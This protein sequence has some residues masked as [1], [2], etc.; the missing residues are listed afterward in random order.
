MTQ[1]TPPENV[2]ECL[3]PSENSDS[4]DS[5]FRLIVEN[6]VDLIVRGDAARNRTYV[7]PSSREI[8]GYEPAEM[9]GKHAYE[10]VHPED[11]QRT[12][13]VFGRIGPQYPCQDLTFRMR[14]SDGAYVWI[15]ARYRHL[16]ADDGVLAVLR[17]ITEQ[18]RAE[19]Q[20]TEANAKLEAANA[21]LRNLAQV[22]GLTGIANRR[23]FDA[24][25]DEEFRRA[26]REERPLGL[27]LVDIDNFKGFNDR[28]GHLGGDD[29]LRRVSRCI[30]EAMRRPG[31]HVARYGGEE[32]AILLPATDALG[33]VEVAEHVRGVV[34]CL[35][36]EHAGS[37]YG[38]VT[39]SAGAA[40]AR[41]HGA[42][43][44]PS[45]LIKAAD[46]ALYQ[47]KGAGRNCVRL[48]SETPLPALQCRH[49]KQL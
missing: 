44:A 39:I 3:A 31:D 47:A 48:S 40:A 33:C 23:H 26:R 14:R 7:S 29:C 34:E 36:I 2:T 43:C 18:K 27:V 42:E 13:E 38:R 45:A 5:V 8:L 24:L 20:L 9:L 4:S 46:V 30:G 16:P 10:L 25:L 28:Y 21:V 12:Q 37:Q 41:P 15:G 49:L 11:L 22:D 17:D 1:V 6:A 19:Q 32:L 35:D